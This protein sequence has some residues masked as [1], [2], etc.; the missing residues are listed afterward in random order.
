MP[1]NHRVRVL[2][3]DDSLFFRTALQKALLNNPDIEIIGTAGNVAEA[4][5]KIKEL[6]PDVVTMDV[7]MP[8][9]RGTDFLKKL[10][11]AHPLPVVLVSSLDIGIFEALSAGA[12]DFVQKPNLKSSEDFAVFSQELSQKIKVASSAKVKKT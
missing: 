4:E 2:I 9:S 11:P 3:V 1:I 10:L 12:V 5:K 7:E 8:D 6:S